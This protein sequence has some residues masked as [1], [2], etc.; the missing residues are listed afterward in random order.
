MTVS[1]EVRAAI[2]D[3]VVE[4]TWI[5]YLVARLAEMGR[6][7]GCEG[8]EDGEE[9]IRSLLRSQGAKV[10]FKAAQSATGKFDSTEAAARTEAWLNHAKELREQRHAL[11]HSIVIQE[12]RPGFTGYQVK[13]ERV[14]EL[15]TRGIVDLAK[16]VHRHS[17]EGTYMSLFVWP[18]A[19]GLVD[20]D[21]DAGE[22]AGP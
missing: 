16:R 22:H 15:S 5:E 21:A 4:T 7:V 2:G 8:N 13:G 9:Y 18:G 6:S 14:F 19:L 10:L 20:T 11:V 3:V 12:H 17:E 1:R